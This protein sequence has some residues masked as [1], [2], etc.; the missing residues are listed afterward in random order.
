MKTTSQ[1][2]VLAA[3][4]DALEELRKLDD[5]MPI[6]TAVTF[7]TAALKPGCSMKELSDRI[8]LGQSSASRNVSTLAKWKSPGRPGHEVLE[9]AE[10]I[11]DRRR[12]VVDLTPKGKRIIDS[13]VKSFTLRE[14]D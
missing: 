6:Q 3:L 11:L 5:E 13:I 1:Q 7:L 10:D 9:T 8:G 2:H 4:I 14:Q 12:K